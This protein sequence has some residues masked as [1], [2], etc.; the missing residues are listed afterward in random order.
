M[1]ILIFSLDDKS[2]FSKFPLLRKRTL[3][4]HEYLCWLPRVHLSL[5][6]SLVISWITVNTSPSLT[7]RGSV[8]C[9]NTK[10][11]HKATFQGKG[12]TEQTASCKWVIVSHWFIRFYVLL[13][14]PTLTDYLGSHTIITSYSKTHVTLL[15]FLFFTCTVISPIKQLRVTITV[16]IVTCDMMTLKPTWFSR[17]SQEQIHH[18]ISQPEPN[19]PVSINDLI[20]RSIKRGDKCFSTFQLFI[21][22]SGCSVTLN[23][24]MLK[25][26]S[27][28]LF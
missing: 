7:F 19:L 4:I 26:R 27:V 20:W 5:Y 1:Q 3:C 18:I 8:F 6:C 22:R 23:E 2:C 13:S 16:K 10:W 24:V 12:L 9:D 28:I 21:E 15:R 14:R 25:I 17:S 11:N